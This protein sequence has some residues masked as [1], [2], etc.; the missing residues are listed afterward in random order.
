VGR[1]RRHRLTDLAA[2]TGL[3]FPIPIV[4]QIARMR[5]GAPTILSNN[6]TAE[7]LGAG[8]EKTNKTIGEDDAR[9]RE[10]IGGDGIRMCSINCA[11]SDVADDEVARRAAL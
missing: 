6:N 9:Y 5:P 10:R 7:Q 1:Q 2:Q 8:A 4:E 11:S 3:V